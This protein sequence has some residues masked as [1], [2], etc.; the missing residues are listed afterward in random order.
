M[1]HLIH[2]ITMKIFSRTDPKEKAEKKIRKA[3]LYVESERFKKAG[4]KFNDAGEIFFEM[5]DY[6]KA[7]DV[8]F[9]AAKVF[10][11]EGR[12]DDS[13]NALR[14][15]GDASL[16]LNDYLT[17]HKFFKNCLRLIP[18]FRLKSDRDFN[19]VL[20]ASL[21]FLCLFIKG[22]QD[23]GITLL[24]EV[25][26]KV[27]GEYFKENPLVR[28]VKNLTVAIRDKNGKYLQKVEEEF[29]KYKFRDAE[30]KLVK[31]ALV[32]A[33]SHI[34]LKTKL[35]L[36]KEEY[37]TRD[38][39]NVSLLIDSAPLK[40][41]SKY[42][43]HNYTI[44]SLEIT[45]I[46]VTLSDNLTT[47]KRPDL[48]VSMKPGEKKK[49]TVTLSPNFQM[50][51]T[52]IG[53]ILLTCILDGDFIFYLKTQ[54]IKPKL[55]SPPPSLE[56]SIKHLKTPLIGKTFPLEILVQNESRG[57]ALD[58]DIEV[59]FPEELKVVRGTTKKQI[60]SLRSKDDMQWVVSL[61]PKEAGEFDIEFNVKFKDPD[62][63]SIETTEVF[64]FSINL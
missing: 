64:P 22:K 62:G 10:G 57:E 23:Q 53:P 50:E 51:K 61:R 12:Y 52:F 28:L 29:N 15:A 33:K 2:S 35:T 4:K 38:L 49:L 19:H 58:I 47:K 45:D 7:R 54:S 5:K 18:E 46:G 40:A 37:T 25:R 17:A 1:F 60:Y 26:K 21:S 30:H 55:R 27:D 3:N 16:L 24:K 56:F 6:E 14:M 9:Q 41:I 31:E 48:P 59:K 32:V 63:Q 43:F 20:F 11:K 34:S 39:I 13:L 44:K 42:E 36:D 8:Y